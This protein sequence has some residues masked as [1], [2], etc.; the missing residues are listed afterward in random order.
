MPCK[1]KLRLDAIDWA[2]EKARFGDVDCD[3]NLSKGKSLS[4]AAQNLFNFL[5][6]LDS[7]NP[8]LLLAQFQ[9]KE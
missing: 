7:F 4:E 2:G 1:A 8:R 3:M 6:I 5:H 9:T